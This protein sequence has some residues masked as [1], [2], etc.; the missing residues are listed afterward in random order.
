MAVKSSKV[1]LETTH[2]ITKFI[3]REKILSKVRVSYVRNNVH[4]ILKVFIIPCEIKYV[5][6]ILTRH[7]LLLLWN[8]ILRC[9]A[10]SNVVDGWFCLT[11]RMDGFV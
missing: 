5:D 11:M 6:T 1:A 8:C 10:E 7:F 2:E 9:H 4:K 3:K